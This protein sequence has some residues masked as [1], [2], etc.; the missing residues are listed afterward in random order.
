[1]KM[2]LHHLNWST[3]DVTKLDDFCR[4]VMGL[5]EVPMPASQERRQAGHS[6]VQN[7]QAEA[8]ISAAKSR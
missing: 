4:N 1:M 3:T 8:A 2:T 7:G 6:T 5:A